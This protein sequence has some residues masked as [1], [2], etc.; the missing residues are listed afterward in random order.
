MKAEVN[1]RVHYVI[2]K[3]DI[4]VMTEDVLPN[5]PEKMFQAC[6]GYLVFPVNAY[7]E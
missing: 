6:F 3:L 7:V 1:L 5:Q 2:F 4:P